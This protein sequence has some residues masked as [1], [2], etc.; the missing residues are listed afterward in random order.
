MRGR[1]GDAA[2]DG[3]R[4]EDAPDVERERSGCAA[5]DVYG[6]GLMMI[7]D[8]R[9]LRLAKPEMGRG[10]AVLSP[11]SPRIGRFLT[12]EGRGKGI[13]V[14][15]VVVDLTGIRDVVD[16]P[17]LLWTV[18]EDAMAVGRI[19]VGRGSFSVRTMTSVGKGK[20]I[21]E[22]KGLVVMTISDAGLSKKKSDVRRAALA[23]LFP[24]DAC[25]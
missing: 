16:G 21:G 25:W 23:E 3:A 13:D 15:L 17:A 5:V 4:I 19:G 24:Y 22:V 6:M 2:A 9:A 11:R 1:V 12:V 8:G 18:D 10:I 20:V 7:C 14:P